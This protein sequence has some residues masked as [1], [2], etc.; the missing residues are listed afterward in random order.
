MT[1]HSTE[2][3]EEFRSRIADWLAENSPRDWK[4]QLHSA[5]EEQ[6]R[7]FFQWWARK[8]NEAGILVAS[9]PEKFGGGG[10]SLDKQVVIQQEL[11]RADAPRARYQAI[12][13][14]HAAATLMEHGTPE[15][16]VLLK[17]ILDGD[18]WCQGFSEPEAGS[19][20]ASLRTRA[21]RVED[22]YVINGQK[23]WSSMGTVA[24]WCLLLARTDPEAPKRK[25]I[26]VFI[27]DMNTPGVEVRPIRQATGAFEFAE[28]FLTDVKIPLDRRIGAENDG[29]RI[30][31]TTLATE[32]FAQMVELQEGLSALVAQL[33]QEARTLPAPE[34]GTLADDSAFQQELAKFAADVEVLGLVNDEVLGAVARGENPGPAGS[35]LKLF[36]SETLQRLT[37]LGVRANGLKAHVDPL[38]KSDVS[39][40]SGD[41]MLDHIRSWTWTIAAGS[42]EIQRN[43][44]GER[45]LGLPRE[46]SV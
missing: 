28:I 41:W 16:Q 20:L 29:W 15:Q 37:R 14:G 27:L 34:G 2:S 46:E 22:H 7:D 30:A 39:Y 21:E 42:N 23:I 1:S 43:I 45:V 12:S 17:G 31:Q 26:S 10:A 35:I 24:K 25:G 8:L 5:D 13:L 38:R 4:Q 19:D 32:R 44:I 9:W 11:T 18:I 6:A 3:L 36:F 33:A 40:V